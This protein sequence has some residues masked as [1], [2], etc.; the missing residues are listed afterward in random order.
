MGLK[1]DAVVGRMGGLWAWQGVA[2]L[3]LQFLKSLL[4]TC[5]VCPGGETGTSGLDSAIAGHEMPRPQ[6]PSP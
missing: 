6:Q 3:L 1:G 4:G 5:R 2:T